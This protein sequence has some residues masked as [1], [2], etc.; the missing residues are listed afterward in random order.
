MLI[1]LLLYQCN[2]GKSQAIAFCFKIEN[3]ITGQGIDSFCLFVCFSA[4]ASSTPSLCFLWSYDKS[5]RGCN[6]SEHMEESGV[7]VPPDLPG[8]LVHSKWMLV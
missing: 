5:L 7:R 4:L 2:P 6:T 1:S 3:F 8:N